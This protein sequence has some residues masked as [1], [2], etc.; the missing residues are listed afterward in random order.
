MTYTVVAGTLW[1]LFFLAGYFLATKLM[2]RRYQKVMDQYLKAE[3]MILNHITDHVRR[4]GDRTWL[5]H[6]PAYLSIEFMDDED[7]NE[8]IEDLKE[9][10][11]KI[12]I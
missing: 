4:D 7:R 11:S 10:L 3:R 8:A 2:D 6:A 9:D 12:K 1:G 5:D